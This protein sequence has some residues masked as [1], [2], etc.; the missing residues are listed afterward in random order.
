ML[1]FIEENIPAEL[2]QLPQWVVWKARRKNNGKVDKIP[3]D[4][5]TGR[6][7]ST[8]NPETW[9][10]FDHTVEVSRN[11]GGY[12]GIGFVV[13][14]DNKIVG[15]DLDDCH[16]AAGELEPWAHGIIKRLDSYTEISPSGKGI[17]VFLRGALNWSGRRKGRI[18]CYNS[19]RFLTVTGHRVDGTPAGVMDRYS[20]IDAFH[21][22]FIAQPEQE[23]KPPEGAS[24]SVELGDIDLI[25]R[26]SKA[27][28]GMLFARLFSGDWTGYPS[29]SEG[30]LAFCNMLAF[31]SGRDADQMD[32]LFRQSG[33]YRAKDDKHPTYL[34]DT[35]KK[36][37]NDCKEV[38]MAGK[39]SV[40]QDFALNW[41]GSMAS[42]GEL[43]PEAGTSSVEVKQPPV[44]V[45]NNRFLASITHE[46]LKALA[47]S[48]YPE[49]LFIRSGEIVKV[50]EIQEKD[51]YHR[52][53]TR[54]VIKLV[55]ESSLRGYLARSAQY[56]KAREKNGETLY[57]PTVPPLELVRDIMSHDNLNLPLLRGIVEAPVM[58]YDGSLSVRPGY[59]IATSLYY[60]PEYGFTIPEVPE[61]PVESD[62]RYSLK[63]L[64]DIVIDFPFDSEASAANI[65]AAIITPALRDLIAGPVP[66]L[67]IDKP[68]QGTGASLLSDVISL[69]ATGKN[70]FMTTAPDGRSREEE[71]R[72]RATSI[73]VEGRPIVVIDNVEDV[74][75]S[76]TLCA[77]LTSTNWSDRLLGRNEQI[78]LQ[79]KT[80]W[81]ATGNNIRLAGD[82]PRRCYKVR[83]DA[84]QARPWQRNQNEFKHPHLTKYVKEHR[85]EL[86]AAV[87]TLARSWIQAGRPAPVEAPPMGSFED[88]REVI[89]GI[90]EFGGLKGF[91]KNSA[92]IYENAEV[93]E[94]IEELIETLHQELGEKAISTKQIQHLVTYESKFRDVLPGWLD[95]GER[96]FT[97]KLGRVL[98]R[99]AGVIFTNGYKL[100]KCGVTHQAQLWKV[101]SVR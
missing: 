12:A 42:G 23:H 21:Q 81:I 10:T 25:S 79:H 54:P 15:V 58:W 74:F 78:N 65:I 89:G 96:G 39:T 33:L 14:P 43:E 59:D 50:A 3:F 47:A 26:A 75:R 93:N 29:Q 4:P 40:E 22:E 71:W 46:A 9:S 83:L 91:L 27:K 68:L 99:K 77:L 34:H 76:A 56:V 30:D 64:K 31:W 51:R 41:D 48:N 8:T 7:A 57:L 55:N 37:I 73:L 36:A 19:G 86:L 5:K 95:P 49:K 2:K 87:Y 53:F 85:G 38:Y 24:G 98:A 67:L 94:G 52:T 97:R 16:T 35:I 13:T 70:S 28:N 88:W 6:A 72:K 62:I 20:E 60:A 92:E 32:R 61:K 1:N 101:C 44:I 18:E 11:G 100:E 84:N 69:I 82:L 63:Q 90:L 66:M 17:R 80:C 45:A